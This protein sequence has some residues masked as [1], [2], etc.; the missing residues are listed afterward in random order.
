LGFVNVST[1][2]KKGSRIF[3]SWKQRYRGKKR[4]RFLFLSRPMGQENKERTK[5]KR[6]VSRGRPTR[7]THLALPEKR[8][9]RCFPKES[10]FRGNG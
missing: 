10:R 2:L 3:G 9:W 4:G 8:V 6:G 1:P 5:S 7:E